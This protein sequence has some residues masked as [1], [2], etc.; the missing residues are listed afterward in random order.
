MEISKGDFIAFLD[1]DDWWD[2]DYLSSREHLFFSDKEI[3]FFYCNANI[4]L[5][6]K[7]FKIYKNFTLPNG[8]N[9]LINYQKIIL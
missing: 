3:D 4:Y 8:K 7:K 6:K 5:E 2:K 1:C 9:F